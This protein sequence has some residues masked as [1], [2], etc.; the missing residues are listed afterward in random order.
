VPLCASDARQLPGVRLACVHFHA[1]KAGSKMPGAQTV[2]GCPGL[3][4]FLVKRGDSPS[5]APFGHRR[6]PNLFRAYCSAL[7]PYF[8]TQSSS[9]IVAGTGTM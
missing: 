2:E 3:S 1:G 8:C 7:C 6:R 4:G 5:N 9:S